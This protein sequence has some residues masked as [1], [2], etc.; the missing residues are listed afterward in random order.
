MNEESREKADVGGVMLVTPFGYQG[1][2]LV[3]DDIAMSEVLAG[4]SERF[5]LRTSSPESAAHVQEQLGLKAALVTSPNGYRRFFRAQMVAQAVSMPCG[6][7]RHV[8]F[9]SP[10]EV[11]L[12]A[13]MLRH[14]G[15]KV[16][17]IVSHNLFQGRMD[18]HPVIGRFFLKTVLRKAAGVFVHCQYEA[19][20]VTQNFGVALDS[21]FV[22]PYH[23]MSVPRTVLPWEKK[24]NQVV[25]FGPET[26]YKPLAPMVE[27]IRRD[28]ER[29]FRYVFRAMR[30]IDPDHRS[31][32]EAQP[33][34]DLGS[35]FVPD[36]EWFRLF[37]EAALVVLTHEKVF[38]GR[39]SGILCDAVASGTAVVARSMAP[40]TEFFERFGEMGF[41]TDFA[42][43]EWCG[44]V[45]DT[46]LAS[47]YPAFQQNMAACRESC[48]TE[49]IRD[50]LR[51]GIESG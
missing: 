39:L 38:E 10:E 35:G 1:G 34:V 13:F 32:L 37:S 24:T 43:P 2:H 26:S 30:D 18:R 16:Y 22:T 51:R 44:R 3:H 12:L 31:F 4:L 28:T 14:P 25:F 23:K 47:L 5:E 29:R 9:Q 8:V 50:V 7:F 46:D 33:N 11:S 27:L 36:E 42:G 19:D 41:L 6:G 45:L 15:K 17:I 48:S 21:V 20:L 40:Q 49:A